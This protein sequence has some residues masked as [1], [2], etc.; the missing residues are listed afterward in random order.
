MPNPLSESKIQQN[1]V[2]RFRNT[3]CLKHHHNRAMIFSIPNE[4]RGAASIQLMATGLYPGCADLMVILPPIEG[5]N[6]ITHRIAFFEIKIPDACTGPRK[7]GQSQ[8][9]IDFEDHCIQM[10]IPY[11]L[12][13]SLEEFE[14]IIGNL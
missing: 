14:K 11:F 10:G 7:N 3:H 5:A 9:Q 6:G 12:I 2:R 4:G 13:T 8:S 1:C